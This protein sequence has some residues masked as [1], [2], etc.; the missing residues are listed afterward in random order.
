MS[1]EKNGPLR[2]HSRVVLTSIIVVP[3]LDHHG[4]V[5]VA[6]ALVQAV[7]AMHTVFR[8]RV[9]RMIVMPLDH[10]CVGACDRRQSNSQCPKR[11][12]GSPIFLILS[13]SD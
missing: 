4:I 8:A 7:V 6:P 10:H 13:S 3:V 12:N 2:G 9:K 1:P 11:C 5:A